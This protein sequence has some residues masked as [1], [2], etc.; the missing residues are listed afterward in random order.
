MAPAPCRAASVKRRR[1]C[2][3]SRARNGS[4][5][6]QV[7]YFARSDQRCPRAFGRPENSLARAGVRRNTAASAVGAGRK[8]AAYAEPGRT[9]PPR[10]TSLYLRTGA[11]DVWPFRRRDDKLEY[12]LLRTSQEKAD[13]WFG[14]GRFWQV[15]GDFMKEDE[16]VVSCVERALAAVNLSAASIWAV[17]HTY[18]IYNRRFDEMQ[19]LMVTAAE[20]RGDSSVSLSWEHSES[21]W[22]SAEECNR[23]LG[24]RGLLEGLHWTR[25]YVT[26][27]SA[28]LPEL[29]LK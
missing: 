1:R 2:A 14:G 27:V 3:R 18:T 8:C 25:Q 15:P 4:L 7:A 6:R 9:Q 26:E 28:P 17:E 10:E 20:V 5:C 13:R 23:I 11:I 21:R 24:F 19:L 29:R 16:S 12:L 22:C